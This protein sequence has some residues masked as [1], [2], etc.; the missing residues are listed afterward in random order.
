ME[1]FDILYA[2]S[3]SEGHALILITNPCYIDGKSLPLDQI[4]SNSTNEPG[5]ITVQFGDTSSSAI[6]TVRPECVFSI[7]SDIGQEVSGLPSGVHVLSDPNANESMLTG[8]GILP[9]ESRGVL[10]DTRN[11]V[12]FQPAWLESFFNGGNA[13]FETISATVAGLSS[14]LTQW[15]RAH[16]NNANIT[17]TAFTNESC[18]YVSWRWLTLPATLVILACAFLSVVIIRSRR[19]GVA[20]NWKSSVYPSMLSGLDDETKTRIQTGLIK[21]NVFAVTEG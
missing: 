16:S 9:S 3:F 18:V 19:L 12:E 15:T 6:L 5:S 4:T 11:A 13:D 21:D 2:D 8:I 17:G 20:H 1:A 10:N 7:S 14:A